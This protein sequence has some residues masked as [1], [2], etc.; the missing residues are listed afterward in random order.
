MD[1]DKD[2]DLD[3]L[4]GEKYESVHYYQRQS[5]GSLKEQ[6]LLIKLEK[7]A[8][9]TPEQ[10]LAYMSISPDIVD[11]AGT[12]KFD[13]VLGSDVYKSGRPFPI[14]LYRNKGTASA[15]VFNTYDTLKD[16]NGAVIQSDCARVEVADVNMD[17][18]KD[19]LVGNRSVVIM[20][21]KNVGTNT[22][23]V[24]EANKLIPNAAY[25]IPTSPDF[26]QMAGFGYGTPR[27]YDWNKDG[28][29]DL[30]LSG[31]PSGQILIF[32][33]TAATPVKNTTDAI[34][35]AH[36]ALQAS[37][38]FSKIRISYSNSKSSF[39][40]LKLLDVK[41]RIINTV[42]DSYASAGNHQTDLNSDNLADGIYWVLLLADGTRVIE[43]IALTR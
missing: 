35:G 16:K 19:L 8:E 11:W 25:G 22:A 37:R 38:S 34:S 33:N 2:G 42:R 1:F 15:P 9:S 26:E 41:G 20:Y 32:I 28:V 36:P 4:V 43:K 31:Y 13:V 18:K 6:P 24:F 5:D 23:P 17:G 7:P 29:P 27:L 21:Y 30:L 14:R 39:V 10:P 12:G 3:L 40:S